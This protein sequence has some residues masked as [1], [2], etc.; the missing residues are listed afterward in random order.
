M[1][2]VAVQRRAVMLLIAKQP[3][4]PIRKTVLSKA[5]DSAALLS[6]AGLKWYQKCVELP[7]KEWQLSHLKESSIDIQ[8]QVWLLSKADRR[9]AFASKIGRVAIQST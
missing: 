2:R 3:S 6:K 8:R 1:G 7:S 9:A 4:Y 5:D